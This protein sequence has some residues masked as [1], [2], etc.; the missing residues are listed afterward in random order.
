MEGVDEPLAVEITEAVSVPTIGIGASAACDGQILVTPD[1]LGMFD[2][3]PKFVREYT[4]MRSQIVDAAK[5]YADEV[6]ARTFPGD[7][8][9]YRVKRTD[10]QIALDPRASWPQCGT[11]A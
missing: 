9:V 10:D 3:T 7:A 4:D 5:R 1:M 2:W 11:S 6:K 8:E